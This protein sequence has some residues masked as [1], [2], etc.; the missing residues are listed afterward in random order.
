MGTG[1][2]LSGMMDLWEQVMEDME[3]TAEEYREA[4]WE[5]I[6]LHPGDVTPLP[7]GEF[8][9]EQGYDDGRV[10]VDILVPGDEFRAVQELVED[11]S[12]DEY[13]AYDAVEGDVHFV[14]L[15]M[16]AEDAGKAVVFPLYYREEQAETMIERVRE[17][18]EMRAYVRPLSDE[19]RVVFT[20]KE[21][22]TLLP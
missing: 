1:H 15:V 19:E 17:Q 9:V 2:P 13:E 18:G 10:G 22:D 7:A 12:F 16:K 14:V 11:A 3:A 8:E 4:G 5:T 6:E 21:P 20:Q